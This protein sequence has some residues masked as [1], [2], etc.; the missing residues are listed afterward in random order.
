MYWLR[1]WSLF[2]E[3]FMLLS[4]HVLPLLLVAALPA[5]AAAQNVSAPLHIKTSAAM[6]ANCHGTN[7]KAVEGSAVPSLAGM[8]RENMIT[9]MKAFKEGTRPATVMHQLA[10]GFTDVQ[11]DQIATY[12]AAVR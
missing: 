1:F 2:E 5:L 3:N 12:F 9:Q 8:P 4:R 11:I 7:G 6:C 10:K